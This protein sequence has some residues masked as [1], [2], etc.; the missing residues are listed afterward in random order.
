MGA[1]VQGDAAAEPTWAVWYGRQSPMGLIVEHTLS[2]HYEL[3]RAAWTDLQFFR[4]GRY[5]LIF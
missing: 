1:G 2:G 3:Q 4:S 5:R